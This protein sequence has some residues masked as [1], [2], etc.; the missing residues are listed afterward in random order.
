MSSDLHVSP[1]EKARLENESSD[2]PSL[3]LN[4]R[5]LCDL[6]LLLNGG[7]APLQSY[8]CR[9]DYRPV[10]EKMRLA[11]GNIWPIPIVMDLAG[12]PA[13]RLKPGSR[14]C[15][16]DQEGILLAV[17]D[18]ADVTDNSLALI[19]LKQRRMKP[20]NLGVDFPGTNFVAVAR[21]YGGNGVRVTGREELEE[22]CRSSLRSDTFTLIEAAIDKTG[23]DGQIL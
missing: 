9:E 1:Q 11:D 10:L 22:A 21:T 8:L 15:Q 3:V 14:P 4:Q 2:L 23:Y 17:V 5:Q 19:E 18:V 20:K 12:E 16:R 6:E 13:S 7:F